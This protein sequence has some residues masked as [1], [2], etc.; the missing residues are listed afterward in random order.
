MTVRQLFN[1]LPPKYKA[2]VY[3]MPASSFLP[4]HIQKMIATGLTEL[5]GNGMLQ[6]KNGNWINRRSTIFPRIAV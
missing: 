4:M 2:H 3:N 5:Q 1:V 6:R